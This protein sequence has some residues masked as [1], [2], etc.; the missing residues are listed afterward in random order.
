MSDDITVEFVTGPDSDAD[1]A[2]VEQL[3]MALREEI[4]QLEDVDSVEQASAGPA[5]EGHKAGELAAIGALIVS[6]VPGVEAAAKVLGVIQSWLSGRAAGTPTLKMTVGG[7]SIEIAADDDQ[8]KALVDQFI[9]TLQAQ[10]AQ[11]AP[12]AAPAAD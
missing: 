11:P 5:P 2:E 7:N 3:T 6:V 10:A 4:L 9:Q 8:K 1:Q 12:P